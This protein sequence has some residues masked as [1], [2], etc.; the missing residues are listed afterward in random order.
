MSWTFGLQREITKDTAIEIRYVGN[1][2]L[3]QWYQPNL[4]ENNIIENGFLDEFLLA[5]KNVYANLNAGRGKNFR[6]YGPGTGTYPLPI[7]LKYLSPNSLDPNNPTN[8]TTTVLGSA[9]GGFFTNSTYNNWLNNY[10]PSPYSL[11]CGTSSSGSL[12]SDLTRRNNALSSGLPANFFLVNPDV[13][14]GG[15]WIYYNGGHNF[16][17]SMQVEVRRRMTKGL[18][19]QASYVFAKSLGTSMY[20]FRRPWIKTLGGTLPHAFKATWLFELPFGKGRALFADAGRVMDRILGNWEFHGSTRIQAGNLMSWGNVHLNGFTAQ[21]FKDMVGLRF[22]DVNKRIYYYPQDIIDQS[23]KAYQY[24]TSLTTF[25]QGAPSGRYVSPAQSK[26]CIQIVTGDCAGITTVQFQGPKFVRFDLSLVKRI[27]FT[28]TKNFELRGEFLNAF[29]NV[30]F[31][32]TSG[33]GSLSSG[34]VTSA[35]TDSSQQQ[36]NGGRMIQIVLRLN[37]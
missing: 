28:E 33:I 32:G 16:Y 24:D 35:Y 30:N 25:L 7:I 19:V 21:E 9:Q 27:R 29:N 20:S 18:M 22:D 36:D 8:Y 15:A 2:T 1:R 11:C 34:Q 5:Q 12:T 13:K 23:Y 17:D 4:N 3:Q 26:G 31:Y 37:F 10:S 14:N 6:Y